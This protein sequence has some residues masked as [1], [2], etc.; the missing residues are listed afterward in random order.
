[1]FKNERNQIDFSDS[2]SKIKI[3]FRIFGVVSL[4]R[5]VVVSRITVRMHMTCQTSIKRKNR[6]TPRVRRACGLMWVTTVAVG[7]VFFFLCNWSTPIIIKGE[8][9][10]GIKGVWASISLCSLTTATR[11]IYR[12]SANKSAHETSVEITGG[13]ACI[14][15]SRPKYFTGI[16]RSHKRITLCRTNTLRDTPL[17]SAAAAA[18]AAANER[19]LPLYT[20]I[21]LFWV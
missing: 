14:I 7:F 20:I 13:G 8:K 16:N 21:I 5:Y 3:I 18:A 19:Y 4:D 6:F 12:R 2:F 1:M 11:T 10:I 15:R 17:T 9:R